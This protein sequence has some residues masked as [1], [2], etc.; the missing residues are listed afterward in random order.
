VLGGHPTP[1]LNSEVHTP[2][3]ELS[4][5]KTFGVI[6]AWDGH[7]VGKGRVVVDSTFHHFVNIKQNGDLFLSQVAGVAADD[8]RFF[9]FYVLDPQ[10][11]MRL[12]T[13]E[14]LMIQWY[15]RNIVYWL[16][17]QKRELGK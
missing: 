15:Y 10:T 17:P 7:L 12:P 14:Y 8:Q 4:I 2:A 11:S 13:R 5:S 16:I 3:T 9:G 6:C 1:A